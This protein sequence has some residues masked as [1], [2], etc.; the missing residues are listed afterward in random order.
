MASLRPKF[1]NLLR[2]LFQCDGADLDS[3][4]YRIMNERRAVSEPFSAKD[5]LDAGGRELSSGASV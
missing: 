4:S 1:Q 2:E 5:L 3:G